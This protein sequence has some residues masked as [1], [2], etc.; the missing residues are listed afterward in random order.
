MKPGDLVKPKHNL[1]SNEAGIGVL[2]EVERAF[3]RHNIH[4]DCLQDY[5]TI[6]WLHGEITREPASWVEVIK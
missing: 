3:Y 2:L 6:Y 4:I 5:L 1:S